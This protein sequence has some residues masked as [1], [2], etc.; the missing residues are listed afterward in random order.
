MMTIEQLTQ[1]RELVR[2]LSLQEKLSLLNDL[3]MQLI[4]Q[5]ATVGMAPKQQ[6]LPSLHLASWPHDLPLR[7]EELY[8]DRGR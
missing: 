4:Q 7:R 6:P 5:T 1:V 8:D 2:Q 3:T